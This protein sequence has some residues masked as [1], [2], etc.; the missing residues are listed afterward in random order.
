M[1]QM[2]ADLPMPIH[3][4]SVEQYHRMIETGVLT[5]DDPVEFL[6]GW[7]VTKMP[8]SPLHDGVIMRVRTRLARALGD[9]WPIRIQSAVT[10]RDSEPEPDLAVVSGPEEKYL[11]R[12]PTP[13][14]VEML[15]EVSDSTLE[16]DRLVKGRLYARARVPVY[17]IVN[18]SENIIKVYTDS[19]GGKNPRYRTR[20]D[21]GADEGVPL[22]VA[23]KEQARIPGKDLL[24]P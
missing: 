18:L 11:E 10:T 9:D 22:I 6:E 4:L 7:I 24:P 15:I 5:E 8:R 14:D 2:I 3:R 12:H 13:F 21:Y 1:S 23:G 19:V 17:W 16:L 20:E